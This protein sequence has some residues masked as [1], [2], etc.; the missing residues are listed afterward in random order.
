MTNTV[1]GQ[2][3]SQNRYYYI[4]NRVDFSIQG[5]RFITKK[6]K[7]NQENI[8]ILKIRLLNRCQK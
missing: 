2:T 1:C 8:D 7:G 5:V 6:I 4:F 3:V